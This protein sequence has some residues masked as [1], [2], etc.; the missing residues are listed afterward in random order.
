MLRKPEQIAQR[1][2]SETMLQF[3]RHI[4]AQ[5]LAKSKAERQRKLQEKRETKRRARQS[6]MLSKMYLNPVNDQIAA[7][8]RHLRRQLKARDV[9]RFFRVKPA[10][11]R[12][13]WAGIRW[14]PLPTSSVALPYF[15]SSADFNFEEQT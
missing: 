13:I 11:V 4:E 1:R 7:V 8:I 10:L 5:H 2:A 15:I 14:E 12:E 6:R 9:A 3:Y